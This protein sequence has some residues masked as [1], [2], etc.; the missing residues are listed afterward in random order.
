MVKTTV[1]VPYPIQRSWFPVILGRWSVIVALVCIAISWGWKELFVAGSLPGVYW[2]FVISDTLALFLTAIVVSLMLF[3]L[4]AWMM[5]I[6]MNQKKRMQ[7]WRPIGLL[8]IAS[9]ILGSS[10][11]VTGYTQLTHVESTHL[12]NNVYYLKSLERR[13]DYAIMYLMYECDNWGIICGLRDSIVISHASRPRLVVD[14]ST[15]TVSID[16]RKS[17]S[18]RGL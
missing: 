16:V 10:A 15:Q 12:D 3:F 8:G 2:L 14:H 5:G 6:M 11:F 1:H 9:F 7:W 4:L 18:L 17:T 13:E